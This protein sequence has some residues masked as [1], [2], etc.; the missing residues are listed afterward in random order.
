MKTVNFIR[1]GKAL[2]LASVLVLFCLLSTGERTLAE[3]EPEI[4]RTVDSRAIL[5]G[6][7]EPGSS[8]DV[9]VY[10]YPNGRS[11]ATLYHTRFPV[12]ASGIYQVTIPLPV[13]GEQYVQ[14][15]VENVLTTVIY[16]R[17]PADLADEL[18]GYYLNI[19]EFLE[20]NSQ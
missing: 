7:E 14:L 3:E 20:E 18:R 2:L 16:E 15:S 5:T 12:G 8:I 6:Q 11:R 10:N 9:T 19:F 17:Y 13:M 4:I 1:A